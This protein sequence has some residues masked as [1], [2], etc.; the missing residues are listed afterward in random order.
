MQGQTSASSNDML[1]A[2]ARSFKLCQQQALRKGCW[3]PKLVSICAHATACTCLN[4]SFICSCRPMARS[5]DFSDA[6]VMFG[7]SKRVTKVL[8]SA[9][10]GRSACSSACI[11]MTQQSLDFPKCNCYAPHAA[12]CANSLRCPVQTH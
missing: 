11:L 1:Q 4:C 5:F 2:H 8:L 9:P 6:I 3:T 10:Y 7:F 12:I